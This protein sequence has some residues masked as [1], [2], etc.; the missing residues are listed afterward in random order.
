MH[1]RRC[2][3]AIATGRREQGVALLV[4][5]AVVVLGAALALVAMSNP[6]PL[7]LQQEEVTSKALAKAKEALLAY[8]ATNPDSYPDEAP[9]YLP[10]PDKAGGNPEG[11]EEPNCGSM[12]ETVIGRLPWKRLGIEPLRDGYGECLW[13]VV[14]GT[15]KNN[16]ETE[17][18]NWDTLGQIEVYGPDGT[19]LLAGSQPHNRAAAVIFAPGVALGQDRQ[20]DDPGSPGK[21]VCSEDYVPGRFLEAV[22]AINNAAPNGTPRAISKVIAG[23]RSDAFN[24]R[25]LIVTPEE[26]FSAIEKRNDFPAVVAKNAAECLV[27]YVTNNMNYLGGDY[28]FPWAAPVDLTAAYDDKPDQMSGRVPFL[29]N[30]TNNANTATDPTAFCPDNKKWLSNWKEY[31]FYAL[32]ADFKPTPSPGPPVRP[33]PLTC[34]SS[35]LQANGVGSQ[36]AIV[37]FAGRPLGGQTRAT[38]PDTSNLANYLEGRNLTNHPNAGGNG[39]YEASACS[40]TFNDVLYCVALDGAGKPIAA[41]CPGAPLKERRCEFQ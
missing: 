30:D 18:M 17:I 11:S 31:L 2:P 9:G 15:F 28:R 35:C 1:D 12:N 25:L 27:K 22:G 33:L 34:G 6:R 41:A 19:T 39:N 16:P 36:V 32:G 20:D 5:L 40:S 13:Y 4:L 23:E 8:A 21:P 38:A 37:M 24:D 10:C 14:S 29:V 26:I 3:S 7:G